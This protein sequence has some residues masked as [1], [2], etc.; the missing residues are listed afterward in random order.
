M[1]I[2][3]YAIKETE[4]VHEIPDQDFMDQA[5]DLGFVWSLSGFQN[6]INWEGSP[7][8]YKP[9]DNLHFRFINIEPDQEDYNSCS[10]CHSDDL[11]IDGGMHE[12][13]ITCNNC[14]ES[15]TR[16]V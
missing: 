14:G 16:E 7:P 11:S 13:I 4:D 10:S 12:Q 6:F 1:K 2:R 8:F 15:W 3:V 5:E 9:T